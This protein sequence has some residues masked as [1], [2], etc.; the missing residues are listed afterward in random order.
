MISSPLSLT[1]SHWTNADLAITGGARYEEP[2]ELTLIFRAYVG[3]QPGTDVEPDSLF[4][5]VPR[6]LP[7]GVVDFIRPFRWFRWPAKVP[8]VQ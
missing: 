8:A 6:P 7:V 4:R 5:A 1:H 2:P 3:T